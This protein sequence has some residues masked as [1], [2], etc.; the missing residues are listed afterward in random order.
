MSRVNQD[1]DLLQ[2]WGTLNRNIQQLSEEDCMQLLKKEK[3]GQQRLSFLL[4]I[5]GRL[6]K[7]RTQRERN[8]LASGK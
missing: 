7:L 6:N 8:E 5:Y 2:D 4:R 3:A 1:E